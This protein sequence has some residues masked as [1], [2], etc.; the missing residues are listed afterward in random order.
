MNAKAIAK[1]KVRFGMILEKIELMSQQ[2]DIHGL[3]DGVKADLGSLL[4][5]MKEDAERGLQV[6][7]DQNKK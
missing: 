1:L 2:M 3:S 4:S 6:I 7:A 5:T